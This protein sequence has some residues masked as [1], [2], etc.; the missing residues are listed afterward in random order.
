MMLIISLNK[1]GAVTDLSRVTPSALV[2]IRVTKPSSI[3]SGSPWPVLSIGIHLHLGELQIPI[4]IVYKM[5][6]RRFGNHQI[7]IQKCVKRIK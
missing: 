1:P 5:Q 7:I 6:Y 2:V 4:Y 3:V